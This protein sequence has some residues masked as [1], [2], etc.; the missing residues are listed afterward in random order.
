MFSILKRFKEGLKKTAKEALGGI[1]GLF[2]KK[3]DEA[4]IDLIE[5][6][7]YGADFGWDTTSDIVNAIKVAYKKDRELRGKEAA[8]IGASVLS[9]ILK[10]LR[11]NL[12]WQSR[13]YRR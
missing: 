11:V 13:G 7:L 9:D 12:T 2:S 5:E 6:T 3:I 8:E 1:V 4:D 10:V